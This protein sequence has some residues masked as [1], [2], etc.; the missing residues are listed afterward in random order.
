M[1]PGRCEGEVP[2]IA[3]LRSY[4]ANWALAL[5]LGLC[6]VVAGV[7]RTQAQAQTS[8]KLVL[9]FSF[10]GALGNWT[11][12][13]SDGCY[14]RNGLDVR[15]DGGAGS[16]DALSKVA[17]NAYDIAI[18]DFTTLLTFDAQHSEQGLIAV[19]VMIDRAP[20]SVVAL[21]KSGIA[22][23]RDLVGKRIG[24]TVGEASRELFPAFAAANGI[25]PKSV[26]WINI[27]PNL[28][29]T[30]LLRG[31]FDAAAGHI[32][33]ITSGLRAIGVKDADMVV[34]PYAEHGVDLFGN[35]VIVKSS[36][37]AAHEQPLKSFLVCAVDGMKGAIADT[38]AAVA[39]LKPYNS[40]LDERQA[41][42]ELGFSNSFSILT[43]NVRANGLSA[44]DPVRLDRILGLVSS[45]YGFP[46]PRADQVWSGAYLPP[47]IDRMVTAR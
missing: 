27:A 17:A 31:E 19:Y 47:K 6:I 40:M 43:P 5:I 25:D 10:Q 46:K 15:I 12:A 1:C 29:Q 14:K 20:T 24:D 32:Y 8:I 37:A 30:S 39:S 9:P 26:T 33:T 45:A 2:S 41:T 11:L 18:A 34:M 21:K 44:V 42:A 3:P 22:A 23:P 36:W 13:A 4:K 7:A 38:A 16:G 28:R 35:A